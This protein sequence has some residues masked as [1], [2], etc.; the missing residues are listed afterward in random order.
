MA[1]GEDPIAGV[2]R[3]LRLDRADPRAAPAGAGGA[4]GALVGDGPSLLRAPAL[5]QEVG[6]VDVGRAHLRQA[7]VGD[8]QLERLAQLARAAVD[9]AEGHERGPHGVERAAA[10]RGLAGR[11]GRVQRRPGRLDGAAMAAA[12]H[13]ELRPQAEQHR[14]LGA[15]V[16]LVGEQRQAALE[17]GQAALGG[18]QPPA[19]VGEALEQVGGTVTIGRLVDLAQRR[20]VERL[21]AGLVVVRVGGLGEQRRVVDARQRLGVGHA[22]PQLQGALVQGRRLAVGMDLIGLV[23]RPHGGGEG[24]RLVAGREVVVGDARRQP[25]AA[26]LRLH[27]VLERPGQREVQFGVLAG[28]Q[29]VVDDLAQERV[30][31]GV[32]AL[33]VGRDDVAGRRLAQGLAQRARLEARGLGQQRVV[34]AATGRDHAQHLLGVLRERLDADH[35]RVAQRRGQLAAPVEAGGQQLLGEERVALA[36][37]VHARDAPVVGGGAEDV[38]QLLGQLGARERRELDAARARPA[39]ELGQQWAQRV[40]AVE[41]VRAVGRDEQH[42]LG[43]QAAREEG[44]E[45]ARRGVGPVKVLDRQHHGLVAPEQVEQREQRLEHARLRRLVAVHDRGRRRRREL[46]E[47]AR[48]PG[49]RGRAELVEHRVAVA[50]EGSQGGDDWGVGELVVAEGHALA[51]DD[52]GLGRERSALELLQEPRLAYARLTRDERER[53]PAGGS[54]GQRRLQLRELSAAAD[55]SAARHARGHGSS[56]ARHRR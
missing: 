22:R 8:R 47:E 48:E 39:L 37:R 43:A 28:Q 15:A 42:A 14:A 2:Q 21:G 4:L 36:A 10:R 34:Q 18:A 6:E 51:A 41:L 55:E 49:P 7:P 25:R 53:R 35:E 26:P 20:L 9:L 52:A 54:V 24:R 13:E 33:V 32:V 56:I 30:A 1:L 45:G 3:D 44:E 19:H 11:L 31:E 46:G 27:A 50:R 17:R 29:V 16:L 38:L 23:G 12:E 40:A 5:V